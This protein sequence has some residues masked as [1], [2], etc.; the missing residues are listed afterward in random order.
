[1]FHDFG[2]NQGTTQT[3][4]ILVSLGGEGGETSKGAN[5]FEICGDELT[6]DI[7]E[8]QIKSKKKVLGGNCLFKLSKGGDLIKEFGKPWFK[9]TLSVQLL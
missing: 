3:G 6:L 1:M 2:L 9:R 5:L 4:A 8:L 7:L